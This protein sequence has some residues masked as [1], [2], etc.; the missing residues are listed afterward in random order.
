[1]DRFSGSGVTYSSRGVLSKRETRSISPAPGSLD[2]AF[3][4][5]SVAGINSVDGRNVSVAKAARR[6]NAMENELFVMLDA[7]LAEL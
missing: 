3:L 4:C 5:S 2:T 1:V 7:G 6:Y